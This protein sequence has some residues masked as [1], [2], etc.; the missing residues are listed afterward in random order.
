MVKSLYITIVIV[1]TEKVGIYQF[2]TAIINKKK[3]GY[4]S[5]CTKRAMKTGGSIRICGI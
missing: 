5:N 3:L 1:V 2:S 4:K